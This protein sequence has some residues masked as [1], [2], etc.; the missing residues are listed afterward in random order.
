MIWDVERN[1]DLG[2][3][4]SNLLTLLVKKKLVIKLKKIV[5]VNFS[6]S[7]SDG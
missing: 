7:V 6:Q 3:A 2:G 4:V 1:S 5:T